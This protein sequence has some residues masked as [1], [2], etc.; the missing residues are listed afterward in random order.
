LPSKLDVDVN[1]LRVA[2]DL[3]VDVVARLLR[4]NEIDESL[5]GRN[6]PA[7]DFD[8]H[9]ASGRP[10]LPLDCDLA[11]RRLEGGLRS[12]AA[13][14]HGGDEH[15]AHHGQVEEARDVGLQRLPFDPE[16]GMLDLALFDQLGDNVPD[17]VDRNSE[18]DSDV[19]LA[20][21]TGLDL[22]VDPDHLALR[23]QQRAARVAVVQRGVGLDHV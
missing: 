5:D 22:R 20:L 23:V 13:R 8:D 21:A 2:D 19:A 18:P 12:T 7:V 4:S 14:P 3:E 9:V 1:V 17:G 16:E 6:R 11:R 15:A 10:A